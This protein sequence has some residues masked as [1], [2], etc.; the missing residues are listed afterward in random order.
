MILPV[1][2]PLGCGAYWKESAD[3]GLPCGDDAASRQR[4]YRQIQHQLGRSYRQIQHQLGCLHR[5]ISRAN[6][7]L[8]GLGLTTVEQVAALTN[9]ELDGIFVD[10][11][12]SGQGEFVPID[13]DSVVNARTGRTK[14]ALQVLWARYTTAPAQPGQRHYSYDQFRQLVASHVDAAGLIARITH[15]PS[16]TFIFTPG[17][18]YAVV[19][20]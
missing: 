17:P 9:D 3:D 1:A 11:H 15:A 2:A 8:R 16:H 7:A 13:F 4:S 5:A 18:L 19:T 14:H 12:N 20:R 10:R 6:Q